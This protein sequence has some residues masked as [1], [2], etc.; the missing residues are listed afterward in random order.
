M[1]IN[2]LFF[3]I[4]KNITVNALHPGVVQTEFGRFLPYETL[5]KIASYVSSIFSK[6]Q[7]EKTENSILFPHSL[8]RLIYISVERYNCLPSIFQSAK[9]GAQT[10]IHLAVADEVANVTGEYFSDCKVNINLKKKTFRNNIDA[11]KSKLMHT[12]II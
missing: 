4:G 10:S 8:L 1:Y 5:V 12:T 7:D 9:E 6:V 2:L 3:L 11:C